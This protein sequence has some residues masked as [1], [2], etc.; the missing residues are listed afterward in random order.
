M[1]RISIETGSYSGKEKAEGRRMMSYRA[2][3]V[4]MKVY[5]KLVDPEQNR[6]EQSL[7]EQN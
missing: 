5:R 6:A 2:H 3:V 7:A 4:V 1:N